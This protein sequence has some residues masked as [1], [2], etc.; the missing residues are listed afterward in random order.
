MS[1]AT[2][3]AGL[4]ALTLALALAGCA[5]APDPD[6]TLGEV[7][8][9]PSKEWLAEHYPVYR[10]VSRIVPTEHNI[11]RYHEIRSH[12]AT[13]AD[14][15]PT[16]R[17]LTLAYDHIGPGGAAMRQPGYVHV[18][19]TDFNTLRQHMAHLSDEAMVAHLTDQAGLTD[20]EAR[21]AIDTLRAMTPTSAPEA[22]D[23]EAGDTMG[24]SMYE[25]SRWGRYCDSGR[26]MDEPDWRFVRGQDR[27]RALDL[28]PN[29]QP[30]A[31]D[32]QDYLRAWERFCESSGPSAQELA[33]VR[34]SVRPQSIVRDCKALNL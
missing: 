33:I 20:T 3:A 2:P 5:T 27:A 7:P 30:P 21:D 25:M 17:S 12:V 6:V 23:W 31:H 8:A 24:Y 13:I 32:Y 14:A 9:Q 22:V 4:A 19:H 34:D 15:S 28:M 26:G 16:S 10:D 11:A 29:C 1:N 18:V